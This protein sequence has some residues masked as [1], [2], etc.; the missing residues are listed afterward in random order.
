MILKPISGAYEEPIPVNGSKNVFE[1]YFDP[2]SDLSMKSALN[3]QCVVKILNPN[4]DMVLF[5]YKCE[6]FDMSDDYIKEMGRLCRKYIRFN[7]ITRKAIADDMNKVHREGK[8]LGIHFRGTDYVIGATGHPYA[9]SVEDYYEFIDEALCQYDFQ[10]IFLATDDKTA[11]KKMQERY[12]DIICYSD[13]FRGDGKISVAFAEG[14]DTE[15]PNYRRG[16]E[17]LRD[18][19]T[20]SQCDGLIAGQ[21]QVSTGARIFNASRKKQYEYCRI[22]SKGICRTGVDWVA[23]FNK[24]VK[25]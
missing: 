1:Y 19:A 18:V 17:V 13:V 10:Y 4:M 24:T 20:L 9:L 15:L 5:D 22:L 7:Q 11:L 6:W 23:E 25:N 16:Y 2:V 14:N 3:S 21:S 8:T 12:R